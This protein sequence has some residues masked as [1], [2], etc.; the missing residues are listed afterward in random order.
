MENFD[1]AAGRFEVE[2]TASNRF[3]WL[4]TRLSVERTMRSWIRTA[5]SLI[6]FGFTIVQFFERMKDLPGADR[7][8][9]FDAPRY[10]G[11]ALIVCGIAALLISIWQYLGGLKYLWSQSFAAI[12]G[13]T[14]E[15][16]Q[17]PLLTAAIALLLIG[18]LAVFSVVFR[19]I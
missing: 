16:N 15:E 12:E 7:A 1:P 10:L 13:E 2:P 3:S 19:I 5:I 6:G 18:L 4:R 9:F 8:G 11:L 17:A 14:R